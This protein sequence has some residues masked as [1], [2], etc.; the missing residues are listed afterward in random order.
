MG[1][2][3]LSWVQVVLASCTVV[4]L[5]VFSPWSGPGAEKRR[6]VAVTLKGVQAEVYGFL[7]AEA[8]YETTGTDGDE[9]L[10][11]IPFNGGREASDELL[12]S[13]KATRLGLNLRPEPTE[14]GRLTGWGNVEIDFD[15]GDGA[16]RIRHAFAELNHPAVNL[17]AG[18]TWAVVA[19]LSPR[20]INS[21]NGFNLGN[22]YERVPQIRVWSEHPVG[23]GAVNW[24]FGVMQFFGDKDQTALAVQQTG[25][26]TD[27][28]IDLANVPQFQGR[29]AYRWGERGAG[30]FAL[31][32]SVGK[33]E[34]EDSA[35]RQRDVTH[36]LVAAELFVPIDSFHLS[37]EGFYGKAGGFNSGVGQSVAIRSDGTAEGIRSAGGFAEVGYAFSPAVDVNLFYGVDDPVNSVGGTLMRIKKN[38]TV[39]GNVFWNIT[40]HFT[41]ATEVQYVKT[42]YSASDFEADDTRVTVAFYFNF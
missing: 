25:A 16:P 33:V 2:R 38:E 15:T 21:D 14:P 32:G 10:N 13:V 11:I 37:L 42:S 7:F 6:S 41:A 18:Q 22:V 12:F 8:A 17:L 30:Y 26:G 36:H 29:L 1:A 23:A 24:Q 19:Q 35:G 5:M 34:V 39:G 40:R 31:S 4:A 27:F 9:F 20:T 28:R 3:R